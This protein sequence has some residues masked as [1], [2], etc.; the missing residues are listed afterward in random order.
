VAEKILE[1]VDCLREEVEENCDYVGDGFAEEARRIHYGETE[2]HDIYGEAT[3]QETSELDEEG[4]D[5]FRLPFP[6]RRND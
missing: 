1:A 3:D 6:R 2:E 4:V 5:F